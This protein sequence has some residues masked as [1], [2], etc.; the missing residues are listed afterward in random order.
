MIALAIAAMPFPVRAEDEPL[1]AEV[2]ATVNG[3]A[4]TLDAFKS[5]LLRVDQRFYGT[6]AQ[7]NKSQQSEIEKEVLEK[8]I[9]YELLYQ[10]SRKRGFTVDASE[11]RDQL[12]QMKSRFPG[13]AEFKNA[14]RKMGVYG[15]DVES[16]VKRWME[17]RRF[18][19]D[20]FGRNITITEAEIKAYYD[21]QTRLFWQPERIRVSH[22][23]IKVGARANDAQKAEAR[24]KIETI[25]MN[26]TGGGDFARLATDQ[27]QCPS[28]VNGGDLGYIKRGEMVKPFDA[29]AF[30]L[31]PGEVSDIVE[32]RFGY[33]IIK[34]LERRPDTIIFYE[35]ARDRIERYL[36]N[37]EVKRQVNQYVEE[38]KKNAQIERF[39]TTIS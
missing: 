25:R 33:H 36:K 19:E 7:V 18:V 17:T 9:N 30:S 10:E 16:Q 14:L 8:L 4:I 34:T 38:L 28:A 13:E 12:Q 21:S 27:S 3:S 2:V 11:A 39:P 31:A 22:I 26:I 1:L 20:E 29:A 32:T 6:A 37:E 35:D 23:L 5:A 24:Q 15:T